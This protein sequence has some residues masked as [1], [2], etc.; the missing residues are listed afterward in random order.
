MDALS[1][2]QH[3]RPEAEVVVDP[4]GWTAVVMQSGHMGAYPD[5]D[6]R[7]HIEVSPSRIWLVLI[8]RRTP[9]NRNA[10]QDEALEGSECSASDSSARGDD[11][12]WPRA[13]LT[14]PAPRSWRSLLWRSFPDALLRCVAGCSY[15]LKNLICGQCSVR[16]LLSRCIDG[17]ASAQSHGCLRNQRNRDTGR[18]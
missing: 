13:Y 8:N 18:Q 1:Q 15:E 10:A 2:S 6:V 16:E 14:V 12:S 17:V 5:S 11:A 7:R 3:T 9:V 4:V